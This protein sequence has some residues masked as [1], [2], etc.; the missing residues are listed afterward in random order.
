MD[1]LRQFCPVKKDH[2]SNSNPPASLAPC[3]VP[4]VPA[5]SEPVVDASVAESTEVIKPSRL[6]RWRESWERRRPGA[7]YWTENMFV[8]WRWGVLTWLP[9]GIFKLRQ[10]H[11]MFGHA[12]AGQ[13]VWL[14]VPSALVFT[15]ITFLGELFR[16]LRAGPNGYRYR[17]R[18]FLQ[19]YDSPARLRERRVGWV[20]AAVAVL[21]SFKYAEQTRIEV[22]RAALRLGVTGYVLGEALMRL[23]LSRYV[24][25]QEKRPLFFAY[26]PVTFTGWRTA[27]S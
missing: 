17:R 9:V 27:S 18:I 21:L 2:A 15:M 13:L 26:R 12:P 16:T 7:V 4:T 19:D 1:Y 3:S 10:H 14:V 11:K 5:S 23:T 8:G 20:T 22:S 24:D 25:G 6:Q